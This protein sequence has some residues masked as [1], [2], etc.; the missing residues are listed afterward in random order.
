MAHR[1]HQYRW[2]F[3]LLS[4]PEA[5]WPLISNTDRFNRDA[6]L[7]SLRHGGTKDQR[8]P[9]AGRRLFLRK[10]GVTVEWEEE[11]F[12]WVRPSKFGVRRVYLKGPVAEMRVLVELSPGANGG[13][14]LAYEVTIKPRNLVGRAT[15]PI[16]IGLLSARAF[17]KTI[18]R[19]DRIAQAGKPLSFQPELARPHGIREERLSH[20]ADQLREDGVDPQIVSRLVSLVETADDLSLARIRPFELAEY[21]DLPRSAILDACLRA[22]RRGMLDLQ[23]DVICPHCRGAKQSNATLSTLETAVSCESCNLNFTAAFDRTVELTFRP[24]PSLRKI[25]EE[26][27]CVGGPGLTPHIVAQQLLRSGEARTLTLPLEPGR[28]RLRTPQLPGEAWIE[29]GDADE[30]TPTIVAEPNGWSSSETAIGSNAPFRLEN[31]TDRDQL[32]ILERTAWSDQAATAAEVTALQV[33][34]DLFST[35]ALRP[36]EQISVG[37]LTMVFTDLRGSTQLYKT[38]G[39]APA[40]GRV[41][42]HFDLLKE[43]IGREEGALVKTIGDAVMAVFRQPEDAVR[44]MLEAQRAL[45]HSKASDAPLYLKVGIHTG[46]CI[47]VTLNDRLDYFGGTVNMAARLEALSTGSD[48]VISSAVMSDPDVQALLSSAAEGLDAE[49]FRVL[50][51]GFDNETFDLWRVSRRQEIAAASG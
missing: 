46:P 28:Y 40:F 10:Y 5:L 26:S 37:T 49:S 31:R 9:N 27:F 17:A 36:G 44:A 48:L 45:A 51:K 1:E 21:Y 16:Q 8:V 2:S 41:M 20:V 34:R 35:E 3:E 4:S 39:D 47:A 6:G 24:N 22:T 13:T 42:S 38:I 50:L 7:P 43:I 14:L 18:S 29:V 11:P 25:R 23:W 30:E 12:E 32:F 33:F 15:I 19:Y